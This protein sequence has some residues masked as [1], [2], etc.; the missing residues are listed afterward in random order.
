MMPSL[1]LALLDFALTLENT[2]EGV[3]WPF[4]PP[5]YPEEKLQT[6]LKPQ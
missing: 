4:I 6:L 2:E 5:S 3:S 1:L